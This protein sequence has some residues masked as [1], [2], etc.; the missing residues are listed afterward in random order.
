MKEKTFNFRSLS[1]SKR[2]FQLR[3]LSLSKCNFQ[4]LY[5]TPIILDTHSIK[6]AQPSAATVPTT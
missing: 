6:N 1:L 2:N 5:I 3:S 4:P